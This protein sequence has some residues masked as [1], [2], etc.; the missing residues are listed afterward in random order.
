LSHLFQP[1]ELQRADPVF[2]EDAA[3]ESATA[4]DGKAV[5]NQANLWRQNTREMLSFFQFSRLCLPLISTEYVT[6][7]SMDLK[8]VQIWGELGCNIVR[9]DSNDEA[10][11]QKWGPG[12]LPGL[13]EDRQ[14]R[15][16]RNCHLTTVPGK[17]RKQGNRLRGDNQDPADRRQPPRWKRKKLQ[18]PPKPAQF[19]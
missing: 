5:W 3:D 2:F 14:L 17:Q 7:S 11:L 12:W 19:F 4:P 18:K 9:R 6:A 16:A 1:A 8:S 15:C 13:G 10:H